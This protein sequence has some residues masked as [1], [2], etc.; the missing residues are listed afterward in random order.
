MIG[1]VSRLMPGCRLC[2]FSTLTSTNPS[3]W[4]QSSSHTTS[5]PGRDRLPYSAHRDLAFAIVDLTLAGQDL[6]SERCSETPLDFNRGHLR[7]LWKKPTRF[8]LHRGNVYPP[9]ATRPRTIVNTD[10]R[11]I[12][13]AYRLAVEEHFAP[14]ISLAQRGLFVAAP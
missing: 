2:R 4:L 9:K 6:A 13:A 14:W 1:I 5:R 7:C 3:S 8:D 11:I 12:A 10:N